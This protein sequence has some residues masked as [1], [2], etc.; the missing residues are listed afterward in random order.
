MIRRAAAVVLALT[1]NPMLLRAQDM[2]LTVTVASAEVHQG[3]STVNPV[4]GQV[5]R[6]AVLL[7]SRNLGSWVRVVWPDAPDGVGYVHITMGRLGPASVEASAAKSPK[8]SSAPSPTTMTTARRARTSVGEQVAPR[9]PLNV[10]PASHVFGAGGLIASTSSVGASVR[11]WHNNRLG[12]Q[13]GFTR[14]AMT[15]DAAPGRVTSMQVEPGIVYALLDHV[16][17]YVWIRPYVGSVVSVRHQ[18]L[19]LASPVVLESTSDN[20]VGL[21]VFAG[22]ELTLASIPR[23]GLSADLGYRRFPTSFTG[24]ETSPLSVS[25]AGHWYIK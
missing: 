7:V 25:F 4:I 19:T 23:L 13:L 15:S 18:T 5:S 24:F 11:A 10:M 1:L 20:G 2:V 21:R 17:D 16:S 9:G 3:P 14:D 12:I 8:T 6:G 22:S